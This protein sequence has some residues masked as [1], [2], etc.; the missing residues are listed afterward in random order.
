MA[1][2]IRKMED[3]VTMPR[4]A[5]TSALICP[6]TQTMMKPMKNTRYIISIWGQV[7]RQI[8]PD[9]VL[10]SGLFI[11]GAAVK[12]AGKIFQGFTAADQIS[13]AVIADK[14]FSGEAE[15]VIM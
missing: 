3:C 6:A 4:A 13:R 2:T 10:R 14:H 5:C 8:A 9:D 15:L 7:S 1:T 12:T 11:Q